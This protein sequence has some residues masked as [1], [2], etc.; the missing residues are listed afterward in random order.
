MGSY[1]VSIVY[2]DVYCV[3]FR[4]HGYLTI[5]STIGKIT[6]AK[7]QPQVSMTSMKQYELS[8]NRTFFGI[9][10]KCEGPGP[11]LNPET[12][13]AFKSMSPTE[14]I[15]AGKQSQSKL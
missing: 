8:K 2:F 11:H 6:Q 1:S 15:L 4:P 9:P 7:A 5:D 13:K 14:K 12:N 3:L 10:A